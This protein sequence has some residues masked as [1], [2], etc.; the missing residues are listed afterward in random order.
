[1]PLDLQIPQ[2]D[3]SRFHAGHYRLQIR[4]EHPVQFVD[5]TDLVAERVRRSGVTHG[6]VNVQ[7]RHTTTAIVVNENEPLLLR[8]VEDLLDH[9]APEEADYRH[10][11][12]DA[13]Q[14]P[15]LLEERR[16]GHAH[17]RAFVLGS[18]ECLNVV[19]GRLELGRWQR[20]FLVELD[21]PQA[22]SVSLAVLGVAHSAASGGEALDR[23]VAHG[24]LRGTGS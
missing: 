6:V 2:S 14:A 3:E 20:I 4:T 8:D 11:D 10:D 1:M 24:E 12:L 17:G 23:R 15:F 9:W 22:R 13:R 16:N 19:D 18:S 7:A 21:G 5:I